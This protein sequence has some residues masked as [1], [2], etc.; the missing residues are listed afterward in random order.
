MAALVRHTVA[1]FLT[2]AILA[3]AMLSSP[4]LAQGDKGNLVY[5]LRLFR[6]VVS[7]FGMYSIHFKIQVI[8]IFLDS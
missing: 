5:S 1:L 6:L 8:L 3:V 7:L 2:M 4:H